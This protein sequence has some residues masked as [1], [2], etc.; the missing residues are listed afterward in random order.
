M[1]KPFFIII[2]SLCLLLSGCKQMG[3]I[4]K[5]NGETKE[6]TFEYG[7]VSTS[8]IKNESRITLLSKSFDKRED[9]DIKYGGLQ[10]G[11]KYGDNYFAPVVG[12][13]NSMQNRIVKFNM[14]SRKVSYIKTL[15]KPIDLEVEQKYLYVIHNS[16][17]N[18]GKVAK[19]D[20]KS[21]RIIK[22]TSLKGVL[23]RIA[24]QGKKLVIA[25]DNVKTQKQVIY[26]LSDKLKTL[27]E[28]KNEYTAFP[29]DIL[30][31]NDK[32]FLINNAKSDFSGPTDLILQ[33]NDSSQ[34]IKPIRLSKNAP[35]EMLKYKGSYFVT[36]YDFVTKHGRDIT[37]LNSNEQSGK[38][39][40]LKN[41]PVR[42]TI[43]DDHLFS[44]DSKGIYEYD[45]KNLKLLSKGK[46]SI[47][48]QPLID[49]FIN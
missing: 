24:F 45:L 16:K 37:V 26:T 41:D 3:S 1:N 21:N 2:L 9:I 7:I 20:L 38:T 32:L 42:S 17:I 48:D 14:E 15:S 5:S 40:R 13:P 34:K 30:S 44:I 18:E 11:K 6:N 29:T 49:F 4:S 22:E 25:S 46:V 28:S 10:K 39:Y 23:K 47:P 31:S 43:K 12:T 8:F 27:N 35:W 19:I 36:H 33:Y